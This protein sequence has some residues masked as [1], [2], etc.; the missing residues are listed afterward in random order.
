MKDIFIG[1]AA[2]EANPRWREMISRQSEMYSQSGD[3]RSEFTR[4]YT[5]VIHSSAYRRLKHKTQVFYSPQSDHICTRIEHVNHVESISYTIAAHLGLNCE[6]TRAIAVSHDLGHPPFG[7]KGEKFLNEISKKEINEDF[8]HEKNGLFVVDNTELLEDYTRNRRNLN[9]TYA[10][11]DGIISHCGEVDQNGLKPREDFICLEKDYIYPNEHNPFTYEGCIV[12]LAD[13]ISYIG[14]DMEDAISLGIL[15]EDK[16]EELAE[17][18]GSIL[19]RKINNTILINSF[20]NDV[21]QNSDPERGICFSDEIFAIIKMFVDFNLQNIY[22]CARVEAADKYFKLIINE[23]YYL[24]ADF[25]DGIHTKQSLSEL[26]RQYPTVGKRFTSWLC[27]YSG[28][29]DEQTYNRK[30]FDITDERSYK[31]AVIT[32]ISGMTDKF[33]EETYNGIIGF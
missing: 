27:A 23:I 5:R 29:A 4:D 17:R 22:R 30:V 12:K 24:L 20:I 2:N 3:V 6:L 1:Y 19:G 16:L 7:H 31:K 14:R 33:A 10:V 15:E 28:G 26:E 11:R 21:C 13:K 8:W 32:Y 9:L 18:A 25:Y